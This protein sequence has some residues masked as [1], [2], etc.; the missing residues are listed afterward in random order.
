MKTCNIDKTDR[1]NRGAI[2]ILIL[3]AAYFELSRTFFMAL[4]IIMF[5]Q[6]LIG[7]CSIPFFLEMLKKKQ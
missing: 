4:G 7:W 1:I 3:L 6:A 2:G 5:A